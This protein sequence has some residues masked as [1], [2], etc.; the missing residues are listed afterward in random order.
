MVK[1]LA[2]KFVVDEP[3]R[4]KYEQKMVHYQLTPDSRLT[5]KNVERLLQAMSHYVPLKNRIKSK[6]TVYMIEKQPFL[7]YEVVMKPND[8]RFYLTSLRSQSEA[9]EKAI[10]T[11]WEKAAVDKVTD[12]IRNNYFGTTTVEYKNHHMFAIR[13]DGRKQNGILESMLETVKHLQEHEEVHWQVLCVPAS[14]DWHVGASEAY[15]QFKAGNMVRKNKFDKQSIQRSILKG[16]TKAV[17]GVHETMVEMVGGEPEKIDYDQQERAAISKDGILRRE[18]MQKTR[19]EAY[20]VVIRFG[21]V[22][23]DSDRFRK[24]K[25]MVVVSMRELDGDN[26]F[27]EKEANVCKL[28]Q[29]RKIPAMKLNSDYMSIAELTQVIALPTFDLQ[30]RF[31]V[32]NINELEVEIPKMLMDGGMAIG[33][34]SYRNHQSTVSVPVKNQDEL[35]LPS[36]I[37]GAM[38]QG[39]SVAGTNKMYEAVRNGFGSLCFDPAKGDIGDK[40]EKVL[41]PEKVMRINLGTTPIALDFRECLHSTRSKNRLAQSIIGFFGEDETGGQTTRFLRAGIFAMSGTNLKELLQIFEDTKYLKKRI[42]EMPDGIHK[43]TLS[44]LSEYSDGRRRQILDPIYNRLDDILGDEYLAECF[45]AENGIDMVE[46]MKEKKAIVIDIPQSYLGDL[47]VNLIGN[48]LMTKIN[49]AM[50]LRDDANRDPFFVIVDEP[51]QFSRSKYIWRNALVE[52]RKWRVQYSFLMHDFRQLGQELK[53]I[54]KSAGVNYHIFPTAKHTFLDLREE[55]SPY[56][57]EDAI[58][59]KSHHMINVLRVGGEKIKPFIVKAIDFPRK[60]IT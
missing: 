55:I 20:D 38:G 37:I 26:L 45:D 44:T 15:K 7:S 54:I 53:D 25:R 42:S 16:I 6:E 11:V 49:V 34:H 23:K 56:T 19:G 17:I 57:L 1:R 14:L 32:P 48:L 10:E 33:T 22:C 43:Q 18:T 40:L 47:G 52:S 35:C 28:M 58:Q 60:R 30:E 2:S 12:P 3:T 4:Q 50:T 41:P 51:H 31:K 13:V 9:L 8:T 27:I 29:T 36:V 39:K 24:I 46:L 5:N 21:I 59:M